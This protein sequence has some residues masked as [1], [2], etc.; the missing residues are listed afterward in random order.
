[1]EVKCLAAEGVSRSIAE[2]WSLAAALAALLRPGDVVC[3]YGELG[4]GK[5]YFTKGLVAGLGGAERE[6][7]SPTFVLLQ[8]Y[9]A[10]L[11][12]CHFDAY[13]LR[14]AQDLLDIGSDEIL[15][16][17]GVSIIELADRVGQAL[18]AERIEVHLAA[19][20]ETERSVRLV[21]RGDHAAECVAELVRQGVLAAARL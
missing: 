8:A 5:T 3:L 7:T 16:G 19:R 11:P 10:R 18:P 14:S 21:G 4:A 13:R 9:A 20:G 17:A 15:C 6:V 2:T 1:L 12:V